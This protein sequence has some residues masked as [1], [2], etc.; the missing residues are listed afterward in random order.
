MAD[1]L[2]GIVLDIVDGEVFE[3][4]VTRVEQG[5]TSQYG[6]REYIRAM[7]PD[8][9]GSVASDHES[10]ALMALTYQNRHV[11]CYVLERDGL[12]RLSAEVEVQSAAEPDAL[13]GGNRDDD[14]AFG[15]ST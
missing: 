7:D 10:A 1:I 9:P 6:A 4:E 11:R 8:R 3:L 14:D 5:D 2:E 15:S 12:G 13:Y